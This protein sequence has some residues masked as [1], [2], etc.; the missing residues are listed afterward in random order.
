MG[1]AF[2]RCIQLEPCG[3]RSPPALARAIG[4]AHRRYTRLVNFRDGVRG[5]LFPKRGVT[6]RGGRSC[7]RTSFICECWIAR[8]DPSFFAYRK[9][10][11]VRERDTFSVNLSPWYPVL[12]FPMCSVYLGALTMSRRCGK[13]AVVII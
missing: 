6:K 3:P 10:Y 13:V 1:T 11:R 8:P 7:H 9:P 5:H 12:T 4:E 2:Q